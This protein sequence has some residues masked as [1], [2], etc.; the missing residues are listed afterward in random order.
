MPDEEE[1]ILT[2]EIEIDFTGEEWATI[3]EEED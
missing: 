2:E 3:L 1:I